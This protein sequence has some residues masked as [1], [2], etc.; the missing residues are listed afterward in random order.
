MKSYTI[1][2]EEEEVKQL[3]QEADERGFQNRTE[4]MRW[5]LRNRPAVELSTAE[6]LDKRLEELEERLAQVESKIEE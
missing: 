5:I 1:R 3:E 6:S 2:L 4:Y